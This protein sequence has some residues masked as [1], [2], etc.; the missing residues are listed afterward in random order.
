MAGKIALEMLG[1][2]PRSLREIAGEFSTSVQYVDKAR[3]DFFGS[4]ENAERLRLSLNVAFANDD[5][6][7]FIETPGYCQ[8]LLHEAFDKRRTCKASSEREDESVSLFRRRRDAVINEVSKSQA[9]TSEER[10]VAMAKLMH[11]NLSVPWNAMI[12]INEIL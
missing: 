12:T 8:T 3:R 6:V 9:G 2:K 5:Y 11:F 7:G 4:A 1:E 10:R